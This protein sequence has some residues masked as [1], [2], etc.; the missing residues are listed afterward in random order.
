MEDG[1]FNNGKTSDDPPTYNAPP[2][3]NDEGGPDQGRRARAAT[4][5]L[6]ETTVIAM[7]VCEAVQMAAGPATSAQDGDG[8]DARAGWSVKCGRFVMIGFKSLVLVA[9]GSLIGVVVMFAK[10]QYD[11]V[12]TSTSSTVIMVSTTNTAILTSTTSTSSMTSPE[13]YTVSDKSTY[14][15]LAF[16]PYGD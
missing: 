13:I 5:P 8:T 14:F 10:K 2:R 12:T 6:A 9:L 16:L 15:M 1:F 4:T 11:T 7:P 3:R